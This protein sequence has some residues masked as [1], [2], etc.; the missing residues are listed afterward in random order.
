METERDHVIAAQC[1]KL[2]RHSRESVDPLAGGRLAAHCRGAAACYEKI[3]DLLDPPDSAKPRKA[4]D[5]EIM[6]HVHGSKP[7]TPEPVELAGL[8][9]VDY[10]ILRTWWS[11]HEF[12]RRYAETY[13]NASL[14]I[15]DEYLNPP[16]KATDAETPEPVELGELL[17]AMIQALV[18]HDN[19]SNPEHAT[20]ANRQYWGARQD[21]VDFVARQ[22]TCLECEEW[23]THKA[24]YSRFVRWLYDNHSREDGE[25]WA[26]TARRLI[27]K[28]GEVAAENE[29]LKADLERVTRASEV[30]HVAATGWEEK[31][32]E[33]EAELAEA[34]KPGDTEP[35][36]T[37]YFVQNDDSR[38]PAFAFP[39]DGSHGILFWCSQD[40]Y[41]QQGRTITE[42]STDSDF[43]ETDHA[44]IAAAIDD[45]DHPNCLAELRRIAGVEDTEP[46]G[47]D[48]A[49]EHISEPERKPGDTW[50]AVNMSQAP[51]P[52]DEA[53]D[54][55]LGN[56][57]P[58]QKPG[59]IKKVILR[60]KHCLELRTE[61]D[62]VFEPMLKPFQAEPQPPV[63]LPP[64][65]EGM[66]RLTDAAM[67]WPW[68]DAQRKME[69]AIRR[70]EAKQ[71]DP[72]A[73]CGECERYKPEAV[74]HASWCPVRKERVYEN[75]IAC[76]KL[77]RKP[78]ESSDDT[79]D[80]AQEIRLTGLAIK[81]NAVKDKA[82]A[83]SEPEKARFF[84]SGMHLWVYPDGEENGYCFDTMHKSIDN[85]NP[86]FDRVVGFANEEINRAQ[87]IAILTKADWP[88][89]LAKMRKMIGGKDE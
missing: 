7:E 66:Q 15:M 41:G 19:V 28:S 32:E 55:K 74:P 70:L 13:A 38:L 75:R 45:A 24:C 21:I 50:C 85:A 68:G 48:V 82:K 72:T 47:A 40:T 83:D 42:V 23:R 52:D 30:W 77:Q 29:K 60:C 6:Q 46:T 56:E 62:A 4:T 18:E 9:G 61:P 12:L 79:D 53:C 87:A 78:A 33:L 71:L 35:K 26:D 11:K 89:G 43:R 54:A 17:D 69:R 25:T 22:T 10:D 39:P 59:G 80:L 44:T 64:L 73:T 36:A 49:V 37:R 34:R 65:S 63:K 58:D 57:L 1:R 14:R 20:N 27:E 51:R 86:T 8:A 84:R 5:E 76:M 31:A 88:A 2:A 81:L 16:R 67:E 3:A